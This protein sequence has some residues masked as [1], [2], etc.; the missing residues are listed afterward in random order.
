MDILDT[1][2]SRCSTRSYI[3][4]KLNIHEIE[5]LVVSSIFAPSACNMQA[6]KFI[7]IDD[8]KIKIQLSKAGSKIINRAPNGVIVLYRN[9]I[10]YNTY[11]YKDHVQSA[12]AAIQNLLLVATEKGISS[13]WIC[14][15]DRPKKIRKILN[16]PKNFDIIAYIALG[17]SEEDKTELTARHYGTIEN[18][19][20]RQRKYKP[21]QVLC[22]N[23]FTICN[24]DC[25]E[26][27][28]LTGHALKS[29]LLKYKFVSK[30]RFF[31]N[32]F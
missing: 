17:Y 24:G 11:L 7:I 1:I 14:D 27:P 4:T 29:R 12:A 13:C 3:N 20:K 5:E 32:K 22:Y 28:S 25:T 21:A 31:Q 26:I 30:S 23:K 16:I 9:D 19:K 2:Y 8:D 10:S 6:W 18:Y 15:L